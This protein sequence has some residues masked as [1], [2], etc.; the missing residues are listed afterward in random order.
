MPGCTRFPSRVLTFDPV[1]TEPRVWDAPAPLRLWHL[2][3]L[4]APTVA[5]AWSWGFARAAGVRLHAWAPLA[6]GLIAWAI[7]IA[8]RLLDARAGMRFPPLHLMRERHFFHWRYRAVLAP[9]GMLAAVAAGTLVITCLPAGARLPDTAL[10]A[11]TLAYFSGVHTRGRL[12]CRIYRLLSPFSSRAFVIGALFTA[13]C[14][15]PAASEV[16]RAGAAPAARALALP[17]LYFACLGWLNCRAIGQWES[18]GGDPSPVGC[19][20]RPTVAELMGICGA[21]LAL[22]LAAAQ[23]R[24]AWM[25]AAGTASACLLGLLDRYRARLTPLALRATADLVLLTPALLFLMRP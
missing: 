7:Y 15:L 19:F 11:A 9:I 14:L 2:A 8:D 12:F 13:G 22:L 16:G 18:P 10:A 3:S 24:A 20:P 21:V 6:L 17:A 25:I 4:D 5:L 1:R 23:P